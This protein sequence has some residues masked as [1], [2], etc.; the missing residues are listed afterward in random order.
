MKYTIEI[1]IFVIEEEPIWTNGVWMMEIWKTSVFE[2]F[3]I[4]SKRTTKLEL[5]NSFWLGLN[6]YW[7]RK[8]TGP[9]NGLKNRK[10]LWVSQ[11]RS[12]LFD[13]SD[14]ISQSHK[15]YWKIQSDQL[16]FVWSYLRIGL[17]RGWVIQEAHRA[18]V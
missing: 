13:L 10:L 15:T 18:T 8:S 16:F 4:I 17:F 14:R 5:L 6:L 7:V 12:K 11:F 3:S 1:W 9:S 2:I